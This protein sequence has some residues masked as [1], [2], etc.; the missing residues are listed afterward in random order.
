MIVVESFM[1][2]VWGDEFQQGRHCTAIVRNRGI[3]DLSQVLQFFLVL[4]SKSA[5][6]LAD[7]SPLTAGDG[8]HRRHSPQS[9]V[10]PMSLVKVLY[11]DIRLEATDVMCII[12]GIT[13]HP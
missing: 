5:V 6:L 8:I 11:I 3:V 13:E 9:E 7:K 1:I 2:Q 10:S 12:L 4:E